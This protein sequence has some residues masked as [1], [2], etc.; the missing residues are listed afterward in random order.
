M[1]NI[2]MYEEYSDNLEQKVFESYDIDPFGEEN[3]NE[4]DFILDGFI[5]NEI[6]SRL[7]SKM[8]ELFSELSNEFNLEN[9]DMNVGD[10]IKLDNIVEGELPNIIFRWVKNNM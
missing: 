3:W 9:G 4:K 5:K 10:T 7:E 8:D 1:N 2:K 6:K